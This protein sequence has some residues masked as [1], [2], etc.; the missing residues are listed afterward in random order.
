M[1]LMFIFL[2]LVRFLSRFRLKII[3]LLAAGVW[4]TV[5]VWPRSTGW[6][7]N[8]RLAVVFCAVGQGDAAVVSRGFTQ[9][10]IDAGPPSSKAADCLARRLPFF[11]HRLEAVIVSHPQADHFGGLPEVLQ[12]YQ[13]DKFIF[14]GYAGDSRA[15]TELS[16]LIDR[17][18]SQII[19]LAAG[20][21]LK[22]GEVEIDVLW[23][24]DKNYKNYKSHK[25]ESETKVLGI[26][27]SRDLNQNALVLKLT[28]GNFSALFTGDIG[29]KEEK[30][31][32]GLGLEAGFPASRPKPIFQSTTI[33]KV[34][35][36][37]SK[38]SSSAQ[39]LA[40]V[41]P[42]LAVIEVGKNSYG[43]PAAEVLERLGA[44]GAKVLRTDRD[45]D[46]VI[47]TDGRRWKV[48]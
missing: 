12:R 30:E 24:E 31:I 33:L 46:V 27:S 37:G 9:V 2:D 23:P 11:D 13:V 38:T 15:W 19:T 35:H 14:N 44:V 4:G 8:S 10:L 3:L 36:H 26:A 40:A 21:K 20:D 39:F 16:R 41:R 34:S 17:E 5:W 18:Q 7:R 1:T 29:E 25:P 6:P 45:G 22:I 28:Y 43:H 42:A 32:L 47:S 48:E